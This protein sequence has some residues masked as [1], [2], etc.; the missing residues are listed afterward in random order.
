MFIGPRLKST[1]FAPFKRT[2]LPD[3]VMR[4][5][6]LITRLDC[7]Y[8]RDTATKST[9]FDFFTVTVDSMFG[10]PTPKV[11]RIDT[12]RSNIVIADTNRGRGPTFSFDEI[13]RVSADQNVPTKVNIYNEAGK[14]I[15]SVNTETPES[16]EELITKLVAATKKENVSS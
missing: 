4:K 14:L 12:I 2:F 13:K 10:N 8:V 3:A 6:G 9:H 1:P 11:L 16:A 15:S 7:P 5:V